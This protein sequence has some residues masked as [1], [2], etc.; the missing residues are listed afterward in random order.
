M[1][2][3]A[4]NSFGGYLYSTAHN[5]L[6]IQNHPIATLRNFIHEIRFLDSQNNRF[7]KLEKNTSVNGDVTFEDFKQHVVKLNETH[8]TFF[9]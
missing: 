2:Q 4:V 1:F 9:P 6:Q 8:I 5:I 7:E 3:L